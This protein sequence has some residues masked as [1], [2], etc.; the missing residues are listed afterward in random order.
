MV[1]LKI[2]IQI[3]GME[4]YCSMLAINYLMT[5]PMELYLCV[6][7]MCIVLCVMTFGILWIPLLCVLNLVSQHLFSTQHSIILLN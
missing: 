6:S 2:S 1:F 3:A 5:I 4:T 7:T